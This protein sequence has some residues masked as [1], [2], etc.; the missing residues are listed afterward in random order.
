[1]D[2]LFTVNLL[3]QRCI[4]WPDLLMELLR[5]SRRTICEAIKGIACAEPFLTRHAAACDNVAD[6]PRHL[7]HVI[8]WFQKVDPVRNA[9]RPRSAICAALT[10]GRWLLVEL[11]RFTEDERTIMILHI[12]ADG[13]SP[14]HETDRGGIGRDIEP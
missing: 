9:I 3:S 10:E 2:K 4:N 7:V 8:Y 14:R 12:S 11:Q 6:F 1:M 13:G 5:R